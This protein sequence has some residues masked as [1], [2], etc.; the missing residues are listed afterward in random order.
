MDAPPVQYVKTSDGYDIAYTVLG[1]GKPLVL[2]PSGLSHVQLFWGIPSAG[3]WFEA[4]S[5][6]FRLIN[7]DGRG[8]GLS[9][10]GLPK[11]PRME[12][13][14]RDLVAVVE[15][16][17]LNRF[18]LMAPGL[19]GHTAVRFAV[20]NPAKVDALILVHSG[21]SSS[22]LSFPWF[23][24]LARH[25]WEVFLRNASPGEGWDEAQRRD[26]TERFRRSITQ[27]DLLAINE[28]H[29]NSDIS[30]L[31]P[32]LHVRTLV[33]HARD[34][35][36][37]NLDASKRLAALIPDAQLTLIDG[38]NYFGD[39]EQGVQAIG[40]F[41][42]GPPRNHE[43]SSGFGSTHANPA[44]LAPVLSARQIEVLRLL[45]GG[46]SNQQIADELVISLHTVRHHVSDI[47]NKTGA[48]NRTEAAWYAREHGLQ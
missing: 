36:H 41:L 17:R 9:T 26:V 33:L 11:I 28:A 37:A 7:Y 38:Y 18:V 40:R 34:N 39:A 31:L 23:Q 10:R 21:A 16:L 1:E 6:R 25:N 22:E 42:D 19:P 14:E 5:R 45:A 12:D 13:F 27:A 8:Q 24:E 15:R 43:A 3:A 30:S 44:S 29:S 20:A 32:R 2:I 47:L 4:L 48:A 46:K 35:I